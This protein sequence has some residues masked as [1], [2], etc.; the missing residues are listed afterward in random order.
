[1]IEDEHVNVVVTEIDEIGQS[2]SLLDN[3]R[4]A[5]TNI[6][7]NDKNCGANS[8]QPEIGDGE[9]PPSWVD[10]INGS[11]GEKDDLN[12]RPSSTQA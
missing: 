9:Q 5:I 12:R 6:Q 3:A 7:H 4:R 10:D 1:M 11:H 2:T 8:D